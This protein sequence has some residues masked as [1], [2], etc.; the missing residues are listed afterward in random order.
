MD[1][2]P[3]TLSAVDRFYAAA[4]PSHSS[5][6]SYTSEALRVSY[7][8]ASHLKMASVYFATST[9][10]PVGTMPVVELSSPRPPAR[11]STA[12]LLFITPKA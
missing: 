12:C 10:E 1:N 2:Y 3:K 5:K 11:D 4:S 9:K 7:R 6:E 8:D